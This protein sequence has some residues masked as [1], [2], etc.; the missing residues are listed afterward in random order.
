ML[1]VSGLMFG[2]TL[3]C[4][5]LPLMALCNLTDGI[6]KTKR[7]FWIDFIPFV[8]IYHRYKKLQ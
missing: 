1:M 5:I 7:E 2:I 6:Y 8:N 3:L 4:V